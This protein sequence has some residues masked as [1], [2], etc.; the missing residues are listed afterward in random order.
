MLEQ[1]TSN[2]VL[3][4]MGARELSPEEVQYV[5]GGTTGCQG[6]SLHKN[7]P[8]VDVLCDPS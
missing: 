7:G 3:N 1:S 6:T 4:R 8:I 5:A 2:R